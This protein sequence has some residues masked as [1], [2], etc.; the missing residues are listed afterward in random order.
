MKYRQ[1]GA[2][3]LMTIFVLLL[4]AVLLQMYSIS[5]SE[6]LQQTEQ[7]K[8]DALAVARDA[9][10]EYSVNYPSHYSD[11]GAGPG[12]LPCPDTNGNGS[13]A[14]VCGKLPIG[15]LPID[16][17]AGGKK[18]ISF[19]TGQTL[20]NEP[21]WYVISSA[22]R[23]NPAPS[24]AIESATVVNSDT[25]GEL[26]LNDEESLI[27]LII[28]PGPMLP[29]Q[30]RKDNYAIENYLEGENAD[31]D[32]VFSTNQ[33]NDSILALRWRD[34]MPLV[35]RRVLSTA[36]DSLMVYR[37][38]NGHMP[39]LAPT[40]LSLQD[41]ESV[42]S[43]CQWRGWFASE[44]FFRKNPWPPIGQQSCFDDTSSIQQN[45][46]ILPSWFVSNFWHRYIWL[47]VA[48][49]DRDNACGPSENPVFD[50]EIVDA[51]IVSVGAALEF[52][53]HGLFEQSRTAQGTLPHYLDNSQSVDG[54]HL[55]VSTRLSE[56][57]N[58]QW[59]VVP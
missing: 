14:T 35:E 45:P 16:F 50:G 36:K 1:S 11:R 55:F 51:V 32:A 44:R 17:E 27:A 57:S 59:G 12:H 7:Q 56:S 58:D 24:G 18:N 3:V 43:P 10:I 31:G 9:L 48:S 20:S 28:S 21:L 8:V 33:G 2:A 47:R 34:L 15:L 42:C 6:S 53:E 4:L 52:P 29:G 22:F 39:W 40:A 5:A 38:A 19:F 46:V 23:Y 54:D 26:Q 25:E 30:N 37:S 13:P 49:S 41:S